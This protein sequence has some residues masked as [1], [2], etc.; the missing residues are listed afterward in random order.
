MTKYLAI[1]RGIN[2]GGKRRLKMSDLKAL[3]ESLGFSKVQTYI[4]S[5]NVIFE[6]SENNSDQIS[7]EIEKAILERYNYKVPVI[8][9]TASELKKAI[10]AN[11]Y[12]VPEEKDVKGLH[13]TFLKAKPGENEIQKAMEANFAPDEFEILGKHIYLHCQGKYSDS[14]LSNTFFESKLKIPGTTR[15]WRTMLKLEKMLEKD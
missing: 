15:N 6:T 1:L 3:F 8:I 11:P 9:R 7:K 10:A 12:Y 4:Q 13:L 5:G 2:V 14:K